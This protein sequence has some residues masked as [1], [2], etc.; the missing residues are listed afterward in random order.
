MNTITAIFVV[1]MG[2][3]MVSADLMWMLQQKSNSKSTAKL[4]VHNYISML[5]YSISVALFF[6]VILNVHL[7][8]PTVWFYKY[9]GPFLEQTLYTLSG[10]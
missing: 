9:I 5:F 4:L 2:V 10:Q 6:V 8:M 1:I 7:S 3:G